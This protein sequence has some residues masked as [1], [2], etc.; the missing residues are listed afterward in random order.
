MKVISYSIFGAKERTRENAWLFYTYLRGIVFNTWMNRLVYPDFITH[1]EMDSD[2]FSEFDH[3]F[4]TLQKQCG[5]TFTI[6]EINPL[7]KAMLWRLRPIFNEETEYLFCRDSDAITTYR[8]AQCV[9]EFI[10]SGYIVHSITDAP[11]H[12][13]PIMGGMCGFYARTVRD[14]YG[15]WDNLLE[16][17]DCDLSQRGSDQS[18]LMKLIYPLFKG[19]MFGHYLDG[20]KGGGE[21][22][23][24]KRVPDIMLPNVSHKLWESDLCVR[25]IGAAG[26]VEMETIRFFQRFAPELLEF[27]G[28]DVYYPKTFNWVN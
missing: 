10:D 9:K 21:G 22:K 19:Q 15:S 25:H 4:Y 7:C 12:T 26:V 8:E 6:N 23:I 5:I 11:A 14:M 24:E 1:I 28:K 3:I 16:G 13:L 17:F 2:T 20:Y 18:L 27:G